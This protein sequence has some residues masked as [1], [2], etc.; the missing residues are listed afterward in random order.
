RE[1]TLLSLNG[2]RVAVEKPPTMTFAGGELSIFGGI[3]RLSGLYAL[4]YD[5]VVMGDL[6]ATEMAGPLELMALEEEFASTLRAVD[7]FHV[8][9]PRLQLLSGETVVATFHSRDYG[10]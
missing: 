9:G 4:I 1:W 3:N 7:R 6:T 2:E 5:R 10:F 8:H